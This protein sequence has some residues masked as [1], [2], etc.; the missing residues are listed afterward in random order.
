VQFYPKK[1]FYYF[2]S[3]GLTISTSEEGWSDPVLPKLST[4]YIH[5]PTDLNTICCAW[6]A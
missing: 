5:V 2:I 4:D 6:R 3:K 1:I